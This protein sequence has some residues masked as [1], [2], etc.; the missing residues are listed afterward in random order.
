MRAD[1]KSVTTSFAERIIPEATEKGIVAAHLKRYVFAGNLCQDKRVLDVACGTGYGVHHLAGFATQII[2]VDR[3]WEAVSSASER[4][5]NE[6]TVFHV[7]DAG[8]L[9]FRGE[10]FDV[11]CSFE[12]IE[13]LRDVESYLR[14]VIRVLKANGLYV[15]STPCV[16]ETTLSPENPFHCREWSVFDFGRLLHKYFA[17]VRL[18]GQKRRQTKLHRLLQKADMFN[19]RK[20]ICF[21][22]LAKSLS[23]AVGTTPFT[24]MDLHD[25][26]IVESD[27]D[28][29][30]WTIGVCSAPRKSC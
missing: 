16:K 28:H 21:L 25:F 14:E 11:V 2:G 26:E 30:L 22:E 29:A 19:L 13:H 23:Y 15:V 4:Y 18:F 20:R 7:M 5:R 3:S 12:T 6:N 8:A 27:F 1:N 10:S 24:E 17:S 9:A